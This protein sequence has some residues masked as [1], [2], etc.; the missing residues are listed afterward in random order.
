MSIT[1]S[2]NSMF[3]L[4]LFHL[5]LEWFA[6]RDQCWTNSAWKDILHFNS[7]ECARH[8]LINYINTKSK[9]YHPKKLT[10]KRTLWQ[11][12]ICLRPLPI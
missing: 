1:A 11:E 12:F 8:G 5:L 4:L 2:L 7:V 10:Y 6:T 3:S 9:C